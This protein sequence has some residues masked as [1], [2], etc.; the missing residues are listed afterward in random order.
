[1]STPKTPIGFPEKPAFWSGDG[2][3]GD[4]DVDAWARPASTEALFE[5]SLDPA[6]CAKRG[7]SITFE[8]DVGDMAFD[9][10]GV[11]AALGFESHVS[12]RVKDVASCGPLGNW[13][14]NRSGSSSLS[15]R[16]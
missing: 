13:T 16:R 1:M 3:A 11:L 10:V 7:E 12:C 4:C 9:V 15:P 14:G 6:G 5:N 2:C 8:L